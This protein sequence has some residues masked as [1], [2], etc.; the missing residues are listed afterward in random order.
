MRKVTKRDGREVVFQKGKIIAAIQKA[1][2]ETDGKISAYAIDTANSIAD[3]I[4]ALDQDLGV[5]DI[6][7]LVEE[8]LMASDRKDVARA[9]IIYRNDRNRVRENNS[10]LIQKFG[11]KLGA[12]KIDNQNANVDERSF[13]GRIGA[14][15]DEIMKQYALNNCM[16][17]MARNNHLN[18]EIYVHDLNHYEIGCCCHPPRHRRHAHSPFPFYRQQDR[19]RAY[20]KNAIEIRRPVD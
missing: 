12:Q 18:N 2:V 16:S 13:G 4:E 6:Q 7:N 9:Y 8:K 1:F 10:E 15:S 3:Y 20:Q 19:Q 17:E 11:E 14:A 5:E